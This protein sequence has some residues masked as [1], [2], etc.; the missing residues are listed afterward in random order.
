MLKTEAETTETETST[1]DKSAEDIMYSE[2]QEE[3]SETSS[4]ETTETEENTETETSE[5]TET[6]ESETSEETS[7]EDTVEK[8][9][10][11]EISFSDDLGLVDSEGNK[12]ELDSDDPLVG[13]IR[14]LLHG[15][16]AKQSQAQQ[17]VDLYGRALKEAAD[18]QKAI[19]EETETAELKVLN[20][21]RD[22][23]IARIEQVRQAATNIIGDDKAKELMG[24]L[25][26]AGAI[27]VVEDLFARLSEEGA[28]N[29]PNTGDGET[30][31]AENIFYGGNR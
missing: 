15:L 10:D 25:N 22:K 31:T 23:A 7:D 18:A 13:E 4:D 14:G 21:D 24:G 29:D 27:L 30:A 12:L 8:A 19:A 26:T 3:T 17:V 5:E 6:E 1:D 9:E 20:T 2:D 16:G 28:G 11:Y